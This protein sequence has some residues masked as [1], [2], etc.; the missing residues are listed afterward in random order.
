MDN[1]SLITTLLA[2]AG[3][4]YGPLL[5]LFAFGILTKRNVNNKFVPIICIA[6]P[7][8]SYIIKEYDATLLGGYKIG[9]ELLLI[10]AM[11]AYFFLWL[12]SSKPTAEVSH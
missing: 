9:L 5:A 10:N 2:V 6:A 1:G 11:I 8:I 3:Y 4:T 12:F 7:V